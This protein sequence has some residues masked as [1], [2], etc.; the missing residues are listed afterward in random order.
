LYKHGYQ[1]GWDEGYKKRQKDEQAELKANPQPTM[2]KEL[3]EAIAE[4]MNEK[5]EPSNVGLIMACLKVNKLAKSHTE[6]APISKEEREVIEWACTYV[7]SYNPFV[8]QEL[9]K[10]VRAYITSKNQTK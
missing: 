4:M 3:R 6:Q 7:N 5:I 8:E 1:K 2:S 10:V 9:I